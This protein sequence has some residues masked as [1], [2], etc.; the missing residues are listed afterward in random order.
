[1]CC[2]IFAGLL[3]HYFHARDFL[4]QIRI[5]GTAGASGFLAGRGIWGAALAGGPQEVERLATATSLP[6]F[7]AC[8][9]AAERWAR[10]VEASRG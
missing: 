5:A 3:R 1:M 9:T 8:R 10:P 6:A 7:E 4:K 2:T